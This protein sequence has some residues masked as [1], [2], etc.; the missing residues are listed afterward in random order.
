MS[1][2]D[3]N[4][5]GRSRKP[6]CCY[7]QERWKSPTKLRETVKEVEQGWS[8]L[9]RTGCEQHLGNEFEVLMG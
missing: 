1:V 2:R 7:G 6:G 4:K 8:Q 5:M 9:E 3:V